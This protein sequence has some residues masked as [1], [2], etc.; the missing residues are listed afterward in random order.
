L[1]NKGESFS[2]KD[3]C[4]DIPQK[5]KKKNLKKALFCRSCLDVRTVDHADG[6]DWVCGRDV[7]DIHGPLTHSGKQ[8][9]GPTHFEIFSLVPFIRRFKGNR[10]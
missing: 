1:Q 2:R 5:K 10:V 7:P 9:L 4:T 6:Q 3:L 8:G